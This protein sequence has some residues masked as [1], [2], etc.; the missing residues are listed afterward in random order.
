MVNSWVGVSSYLGFSL[1]LSVFVRFPFVSSCFFFI[2]LS[3]VNVIDLFHLFLLSFSH[4][5]FLLCRPPFLVYVCFS[6]C[7]CFHSSSVLVDS[8]CFRPRLHLLSSIVLSCC[9]HL[10][11]CFSFVHPFRKF[12]LS[13]SLISYMFSP[14]KFTGRRVKTES[15]VSYWL[16]LSWFLS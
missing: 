3:F 5:C 16:I 15:V 12:F 7:L 14:L 8:C 10:S 2:C 1:F 11:T 13:F 4:L 9:C 6:V